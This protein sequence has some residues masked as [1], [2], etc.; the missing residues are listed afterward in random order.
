[1]ISLVLPYWDRQQATDAALLRLAELYS[2]TGLEVIVVD[3]GS[4]VPFVAPC[5]L[6][7]DV[8]VV[9]LPTK[10]APKNPCV[11]I[12]VGVL[13]A[14]RDFIALSNPETRHRDRVLPEL[15]SEAMRGGR[16]TYA[17]AAAWHPEGGNWH[18][19]G[20]APL[21]EAEGIAFP[22]GS[23][24]HFMSLM[25][26]DLWEA[27]GG[28]DESYRDG[29]GY[30]DADFVLHLASAGARFVLRDDVVVE[31]VRAGARAKWTAEMFARNRALFRRK[32]GRRA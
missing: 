22:R 23:H 12:N 1:M 11:P 9:R 6:P 31:H 24:L 7:L 32:W 28:F 4:P 25:H 3:D 19:H 16:C 29:A 10:S 20:S 13:H 15:L 30:E 8:K 27:A 18:C 14:S 5:G 2:G 26:R 17:L 21:R